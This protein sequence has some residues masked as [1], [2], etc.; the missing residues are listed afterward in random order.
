MLKKSDITLYYFKLNFFALGFI[1]A[2]MMCYGPMYLDWRGASSTLLSWFFVLSSL[3]GFFAQ[4][5][6]GSIF[7]CY[8]RVRFYLVFSLTIDLLMLAC[9]LNWTHPV[10]FVAGYCV[11]TLLGYAF[12]PAVQASVSILYPHEVGKRI[13]ELLAYR[14]IGWMAASFSGIIVFLKTDISMISLLIKMAIVIV[15]ILLLC[16]PLV[17]LP[18]RLGVR[19]RMTLPLSEQFRLFECRPELRRFALLLLWVAAGNSLFFSYF[20]VYF[21][22]VIHGAEWGVG[23]S[24]L[25][26][27]V[28]GSISYPIYGIWG[29]RRGSYPVMNFSVIAYLCC[30]LTLALCMN[31]WIVIIVYG[32]PAYSALRIAGN[33]FIAG[34]TDPEERGTGMGLMEGLHALGGVVGPAISGIFLLYLD[35]AN[36][37]LLAAVFMLSYWLLYFALPDAQTKN[38]K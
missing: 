21:K 27:S 6:W 20:G 37:P 24:M 9:F 10:F 1:E 26:A 34:H 7:D 18:E 15:S 11:Q 5:I 35:Y 4:N 19:K 12:F 36:L 23:L 14:S 38:P 31:P 22:H 13:G 25:L 33:L 2:V 16:S 8:S 32:F 30:Y 17:F 28:F 3:A 29:D